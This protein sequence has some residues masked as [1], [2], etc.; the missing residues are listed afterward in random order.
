[1]LQLFEQRGWKKNESIYDNQLDTDVSGYVTGQNYIQ[2]K[3]LLTHLIFGL[4][5]LIHE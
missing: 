4:L 3:Y 2:V 1:M 5:A